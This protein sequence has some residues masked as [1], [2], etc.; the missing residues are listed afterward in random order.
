MMRHL[1]FL[2][3]RICVPDELDMIEHYDTRAERLAD[4]WVHAVGLGF[5]AAGGLVLAVLAAIYGGIG[6]ATATAVYAVCLVVMLTS[7]TI[8]NLTRPCAARPILRRI[9]EAAIF[10]MIAGSY[11]PFTLRFEGGWAVGFTALVWAIALTGVA[12]KLVAPR[13]NDA[14]WSLVYIG[15][16]WLAVLALRPMTAAIEAPA[17]WLL[18][19][20]GLIY[21]AGV[22]VFIS[23][24]LPYRRAIWH[25]FVVAGAG[26]HW[27][28]VLLS[29]VLAPVAG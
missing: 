2:S 8:Y 21:T 11:T 13:I 9:D 17:L 14:F 28:A 22:F 19:A 4:L 27:T 3:R 26:T 6:M 16:G 18:A 25:G 15:F 24:K 29:V 12:V 7:S 23:R 1:K 20:G 10:L 5:A